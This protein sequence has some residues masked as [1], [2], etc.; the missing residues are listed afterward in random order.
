MQGADADQG[1]VLRD[2]RGA[3]PERV[4]RR[5]EDGAVEQVFPMAGEFLAGDDG[6][7]NRVPAAA[8]GGDDRLVAGAD[9]PAAADLDRRHR[10]AP[11]RLHQPEPGL[12]V[13]AEHRRRHRAADAGG[14][15]DRL[16]LGDQITDGQHQPVA[17]DQDGAAGALG[18]E[19]PGGERVL[20]NR[21]L[22]PQHRAQRAVQIEFV[23]LRLRLDLGRY[24]PFDVSRHRSRL[25][26]SGCIYRTRQSAPGLSRLSKPWGPGTVGGS[27]AGRPRW[28]A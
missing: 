2:Q 11:E 21:R 10:Q 26:G 9:P 14:Q 6:R 5:G 13:V 4:R 23:I 27:V 19:R 3:A 15:P 18:A 17:A 25:V 1:A 8:L 7:G 12:L 24:F 20:R 16:G 28:L 22:Q